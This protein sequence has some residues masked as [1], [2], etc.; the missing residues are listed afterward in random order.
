MIIYKYI[1]VFLRRFNYFHFT[2]LYILET[3]PDINSEYHFTYTQDDINNNAGDE[4]HIYLEQSPN[5][6]EFRQRIE[7]YDAYS[8]VWDKVAKTGKILAHFPEN[9]LVKL[10]YD[11]REGVGEYL[12]FDTAERRLLQANDAYYFRFDAGDDSWLVAP[13]GK[14]KQAHLLEKMTQ[15]ANIMLAAYFGKPTKFE[16]EFPKVFRP[17][18]AI[19]SNTQHGCMLFA[20]LG[21][22][23]TMPMMRLVAD[24]L[25]IDLQIGID[26]RG[27]STKISYQGYICCY[28][29]TE[30]QK[31]NMIAAFDA[32]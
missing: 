17:Q 21:A 26:L 22:G 29:L 16:F 2:T 9:E 5:S 10:C 28:A 15:L 12:I 27:F 32:F 11:E 31:Q 13:K 14:D 7:Q 18:N 8:E 30:S 20:Y 24:S 23:N 3:Y 6:P 4:L 25:P 19:Y 1:S